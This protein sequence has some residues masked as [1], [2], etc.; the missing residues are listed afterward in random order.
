MLLAG[1]HFDVFEIGVGV[2][3]HASVYLTLL[4]YVSMSTDDVADKE[5]LAEQWKKEHRHT[6]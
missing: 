6:G 3:K 2:C 4:L 1:S 5:L